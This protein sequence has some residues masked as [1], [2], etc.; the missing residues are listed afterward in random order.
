ML[1]TN[2]K[3]TGRW[4]AAGLIACLAIFAP[5][6][7]KA[8]SPLDG[9]T[10]MT[11]DYPPFNY[12]ENGKL[13]GISTEIVVEMLKRSGSKKGLKDIQLLS[14]ARGYAQTL[15]KPN[16][17]LFSTTRTTSREPLFKWVGPFVPTMV[18]LI[19]K[20]N[21]KLTISDMKD[22]AKLRI[23]VV[24]DDIGHL[25][26]K[27]AGV[28]QDRLEAVLLNEQNYRKLNAG[29]VD[30]IAYETNVTNWHFGKMG[31]DPDEFEVIHVLKRSDLYLAL[32]KDTPD[33]IVT[34]L[35]A[36]LDQIKQDGTYDK[37]L[38]NCNFTVH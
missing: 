13:S 9:L 33:S 6:S 18:A 20:K 14:W 37:I 21:S 34:R 26:L 19:A 5:I 29:R 25:L 16:H 2:M 22:L 31:Y 10:I 17:A 35:Q 4:M 24:K 8:Q 36:L 27:E 12:S 11:E 32:H 1:D 38:K 7:S 28:P 3:G 15:E 23:G 30:A